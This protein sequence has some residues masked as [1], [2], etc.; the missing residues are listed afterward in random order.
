MLVLDLDGFATLYH[1]CDI[2]MAICRSMPRKRVSELRVWLIQ[3]L[4]INVLINSL[5]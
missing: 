2:A 3:K 5:A 4:F 1:D